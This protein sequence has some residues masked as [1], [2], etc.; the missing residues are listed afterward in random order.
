MLDLH[1]VP[2]DGALTFDKLA[3]YVVGLVVGE[4]PLDCVRMLELDEGEAFDLLGVVIGWDNDV[5]NF[6]KLLKVFSERIFGGFGRETPNE[7]FLSFPIAFH[8][9]LILVVLVLSDLNFLL[10]EEVL[11]GKDGSCH[12]AGET[13]LREAL[14]LEK[15]LVSDEL[16]FPDLAILGEVL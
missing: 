13:D 1:F 14:R 8:D 10:L 7:N 9:K 12:R 16:E 11:L 4:H 5:K 2:V 6:A 3:I 15:A